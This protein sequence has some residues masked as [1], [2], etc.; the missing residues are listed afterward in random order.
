MKS[1]VLLQRNL[2]IDQIF[3]STKRLH[4][5]SFAS[6][7]S[8]KFQ[9]SFDANEVTRAYEGPSGAQSDDNTQGMATFKVKKANH[10]QL[11]D[12][13]DDA[14]LTSEEIKT[15]CGKHDLSRR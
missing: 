7:N 15:I 5:C 8:S 9:A 12:K 4:K 1:A 14:M 3:E 11:T 13:S 10:M 6:K 2:H